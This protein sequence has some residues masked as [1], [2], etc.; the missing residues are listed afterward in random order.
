MQAK[1]YRSLFFLIFINLLIKPVW[2]LGVDR[3]VQNT[4]GT[5][6]YGLYFALFNLSFYLQI[7]LDPGFYTFNSK[8]IAENNSMLSEY[9]SAFVPIK[10]LLSIVYLVL[11]VCL[12]IFLGFESYAVKILFWIGI[13][14]ILSSMLLYFRS[15]L[16]GLHHFMLDS[17]FSVL[18]RFLMIII[19]GFILWG[20]VFGIRMDIIT[21]VHAQNVS[22]LIVTTGAGIIV[23]KKATYFKPVFNI[24]FMNMVVKKSLPYALLGILMTLYSRIDSLMLERMLP[25]EEGAFQAGLYASAYRLMDAANMIAFLMSTVLLPVFSGLISR[26]ETSAIKKTAGSSFRI[27]IVPALILVACCFVFRFPIMNLLYNDAAVGGAPVFGLLMFSFLALCM[28]YVYG[29]LLTAKGDMKFLIRTAMGGVFLN[30]ILNFLLIPE[31]KAMGTVSAT[32]LTQFIVCGSQMFRAHRLFNIKITTK[33]FYL[34]AIAGVTIPLIF[35]LMS[36]SPLVWWLNM[37]IASFACVTFAL[38]SGIINI[39]FFLNLLKNTNQAD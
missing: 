15:N 1:H 20:S 26:N 4:V 16:S 37:F 31:F 29:T 35:F 21:F 22:L 6:N 17:V 10:F 11:T 5:A 33:D 38:I 3:E 24:P 23:W 7:I 14:Q 12:G 9:F 2:L 13:S 39:R 27:L 18:D 25:N 30:I 36:F 32:L 34:T 28:M 8:S 19:C